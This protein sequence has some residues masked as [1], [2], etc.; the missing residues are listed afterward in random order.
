ME[1]L[2]RIND[3]KEFGIETIHAIVETGDPR[4]L[5]ATVLP[6]QESIDLIVMGATG[7]GSIQ[8]A[9]VGSTAL[10]SDTC[11]LQCVSCK[12][13][14]DSRKA[15]LFIFNVAFDRKEF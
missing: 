4:T 15:A 6:K 8:Q 13:D 3:A 14:Y 5:L 10:C 11:A 2:K 12:I 7:K 9:L 1:L